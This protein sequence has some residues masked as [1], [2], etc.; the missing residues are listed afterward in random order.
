MSTTSSPA[1]GT[2]DPRDLFDDA[3]Q[4]GV[5][6][7][8][9]VRR[10]FRRYAVFSGRASRSEY[11]WIVL[12]NFLVNLTAL[13]LGALASAVVDSTV[14]SDSPA[15]AWAVVPVVVLTAG[16]A[17]FALVPGLSLT[18]RRLHDANFSGWWLLLALVPGAALVV[19][20]FS[21]LPSSPAGARF[22]RAV[23]IPP[24]GTYAAGS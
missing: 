1:P 22:D 9:A 6:L 16:Y 17:L 15:F 3:P 2:I 14:G 21:L 19:V 24:A 5:S 11:W 23:P 7:P 12:F 20:V 4:P 10:W 18:V 8:E 13:V